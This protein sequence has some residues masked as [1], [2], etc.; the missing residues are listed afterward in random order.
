MPGVLDVSGRLVDTVAIRAGLSVHGSYGRDVITAL[1]DAVDALRSQ[2]ARQVAEWSYA[3]A[4]EVAKVAA[5][6]ALCDECEPTCTRTGDRAED[7][8]EGRGCA[9][10]LVDRDAVL[11]ALD[12][13]S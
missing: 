5:V 7:Y 10:Y 13:P 11:R 9:V 8:C 12:G 6:R 2:A 4:A 1:C 3:F